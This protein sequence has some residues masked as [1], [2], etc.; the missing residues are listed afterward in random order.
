MKVIGL[1]FVILGSSGFGFYMSHCFQERIKQL[2]QL[3]Q[4]LLMLEGE[5]RYQNTLLQ[6][7]F[8]IMSRRLGG[9]QKYFLENLG[10]KYDKQ[11][12]VKEVEKLPS[13]TAFVEDDIKLLL[14]LGGQLGYLDKEMQMNTLE[15]YKKRLLDTIDILE[16]QKNEKCKL[17][18]VLGVSCGM[19]VA[20]LLL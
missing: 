5:I 15:F 13:Y 7:A 17:Y 19:L 11:L 14:E 10:E 18:R 4:M 6:E 20:L 3:Y 1:L 12:W 2:R 16:R 9:W 8:F